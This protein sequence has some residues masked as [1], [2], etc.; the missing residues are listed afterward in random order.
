L[1]KGE[2]QNKYVFYQIATNPYFKRILLTDNHILQI[3]NYKQGLLKPVKTGD[4][5]E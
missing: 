5:K 2:N 4:F 3:K 1:G